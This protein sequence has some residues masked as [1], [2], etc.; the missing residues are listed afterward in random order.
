MLLSI[1]DLTLDTINF[2]LERGVCF[3]VGSESDILSIED[4]ENYSDALWSDKDTGDGS[5]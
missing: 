3:D 1:N 5:I 4:F 2:L